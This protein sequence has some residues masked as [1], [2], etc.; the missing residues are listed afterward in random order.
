MKLL[1]TISEL[2]VAIFRQNT[3]QITLRPNAGTTY[4][5]DRVGSLPNQDADF[6]LV[7]KDANQAL[8]NKTIDASLNTLSNIA[9]SNVSA[10]AAIDWSKINKSGSN[11]TD[12]ATRSHTSLSDIGTTTHA[13]IDIALSASSGHIGAST[14][15][16]GL[17]VGSAVV[18]TTDNQVLTTKSISGDT[19]TI[20]N[21][22]VSTLKTV[23]GQAFKFLSFDV[24]GAPI[25]TKS[26]PTGDVVGTS[27]VQVLTNKDID[28]GSASNSLRVTIPKGTTAA[29]TAL[30]RK[31]GTLLYST[32]DKVMYYDN[33]VTLSPVGSAGLKTPVTLTASTTLGVAL[34]VAV[35]SY[36]N[37]VVK[38][39][40]VRGAGERRM[41]QIF[42]MYDGTGAHV[43]DSYAEAADCGVEFDADVS[44]GSLRLL[45][46]TTGASCSMVYFLDQWSN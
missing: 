43:V 41:G 11:L 8:T 19:N 45:Y 22:A 42:L 28:G 25:A 21:L 31:E 4:S 15:V 30:T 34:S 33:G 16:H 46:T 7:S 10:T 9:N 24:S 5:A 39:S 32:D 35:A 23:I 44:G 38:Y 29:I 1:G 27:D 17:G 3:K 37:V 13:N 18:G 14:N 20:S 12:I 2:V 36:Q 6:E 40:L 26:V